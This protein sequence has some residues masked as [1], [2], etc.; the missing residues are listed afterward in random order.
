MACYSFYFVIENNVVGQMIDYIV[1][2]VNVD[3]IIDLKI[4]VKRKTPNCL[5][6]SSMPFMPEHLQAY[7]SD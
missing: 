2:S 4:K 1:W 5:C 3:N 7:L 6:V